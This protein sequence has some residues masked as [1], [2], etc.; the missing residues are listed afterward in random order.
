MN[1]YN[2]HSG[3]PV[4]LF[5]GMSEQEAF[6]TEIETIKCLKD[7]GYK[8]ANL[9]DGGEGTSGREVT[10]E[11]REKYRIMNTG[12]GNPNYG[13]K[14][15]DE[16]RDH[17]SK[18]RKESK[19]AALGNNPR[20]HPVMCV[21]TGKIYSCKQEAA[22]DLGL[23]SMVSISHALYE[24]RFVAKGFHFV[25]GET[26]QRLNTEEKRL[27]YLQQIEFEKVALYSDI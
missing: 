17:L 6:D 12:K 9:T 1:I 26:I 19:V 20:A 25:D 22:N 23:K 21:E 15:S 7:K 3:I 27:Q 5:D 14:W 13:N 24:R 16:Q 8:L 10:E 2:K 11:Y 18:V 4:I